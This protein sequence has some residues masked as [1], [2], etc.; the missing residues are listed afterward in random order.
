MKH[1]KHCAVPCTTTSITMSAEDRNHLDA[2][3]ERFYDGAIN[4]M[5]S[6]SLMLAVLVDWAFKHG[7]G[8]KNTEKNHE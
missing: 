8:P 2:I 1:R 6:R 7:F 4:Q 3:R 5:P